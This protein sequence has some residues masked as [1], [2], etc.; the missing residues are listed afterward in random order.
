MLS[1]PEQ[2]FPAK[3]VPDTV[4]VVEVTVVETVQLKVQTVSEAVAD[5]NKFEAIPERLIVGVVAKLFE[6][7][8]VMVVTLVFD[9]ILSVSVTERITEINGQVPHTGLLA[10]VSAELS[11]KKVWFSGN[12]SDTPIR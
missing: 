3:S 4:A 10:S 7:S 11:E 5:I 12:I 6:K 8:A 9:T 2:T 1:V